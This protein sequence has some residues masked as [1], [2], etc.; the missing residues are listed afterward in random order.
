MG[1]MADKRPDARRYLREQGTAAGD[2]TATVDVTELLTRLAERTEELAE[3]RARQKHAE[4]RL[5]RKRR[6]IYKERKIHEETLEQLETDCRELEQKCHQAAAEYRELEGQ[7]DRERKARATVEADLKRAQQRA[8]AVQHR[9]Q[10]ARAQLEEGDREAER[11]PWWERSGLG[12]AAHGVFRR[13]GSR[14]TG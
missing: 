3:A 2:T 5:K 14:D 8:A 7:A 4:A 10:I 13:F 9:L 6:E 12:P 11:R 1:Y